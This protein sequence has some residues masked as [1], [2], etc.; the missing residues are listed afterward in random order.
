MK[1]KKQ[2]LIFGDSI[3]YGY[4]DTKGGWGQRLKNFLYERDIRLYNLSISANIT[5]DLLKRLEFETEQRLNKEIVFI[6]A[7]GINDCQFLHSQNKLRTEPKKFEKNIQKIIDLARKYSSE[8]LF[9]GLTPVDEEKTN[10]IPW[11]TNTFYKNNN[12]QKF[13]NIIKSTCNKNNIYFI[14]LF[15]KFNKRILED[16][17]HPNSKGHQK[18]FEIVKNFLDENKII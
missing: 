15:E 1:Q 12:I 11:G 6:F 3:A 18:I 17:L 8:I 9:I 4:R 2:I 13:D 7:I 16:G 10:P 5:V 14:N